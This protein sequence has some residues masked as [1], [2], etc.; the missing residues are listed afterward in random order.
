MTLPHWSI[1]FAT[2]DGATQARGLQD[3]RISLQSFSPRIERSA[4]RR[5]LNFWEPSLPYVRVC[6]AQC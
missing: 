5:H 3:C 4:A 2:E 6:S 1:S